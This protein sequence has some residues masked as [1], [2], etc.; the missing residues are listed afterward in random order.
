V[1]EAQEALSAFV[2]FLGVTKP[3]GNAKL[4]EKSKTF[5]VRGY[6]N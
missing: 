4:L 2:P 6:V 3:V 1:S 5:L